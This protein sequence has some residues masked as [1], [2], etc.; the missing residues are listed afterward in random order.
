MHHSLHHVHTV[1]R[2]QLQWHVAHG[3]HEFSKEI[4]HLPAVLQKYI[5]ILTI[6]EVGVAQIGPVW[7]IIIS[8]SR[9]CEQI[10]KQI[11]KISI[12]P[13]TYLET[14]RAIAMGIFCLKELLIYSHC[15]HICYTAITY[16]CEHCVV[17][18]FAVTHAVHTHW[19][20]DCCQKGMPWCAAPR[21]FHWSVREPEDVAAPA[22]QVCGTGTLSSARENAGAVAVTLCGNCAYL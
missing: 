15:N 2:L 14:L 21:W 11:S 18:A 5:P 3:S 10:F 8:H 9:V 17:S 7:D 16:V 6:G 4:S 1:V 12:W 20:W 13:K 22:G 19:W